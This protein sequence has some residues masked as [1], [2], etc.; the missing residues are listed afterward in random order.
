M[1]SRI[2]EGRLASDSCLSPVPYTKPPAVKR[3]VFTK[4][5]LR[6]HFALHTDPSQKEMRLENSTITLLLLLLSALLVRGAEIQRLQSGCGLSASACGPT[7]GTQICE[8]SRPTSSPE[9]FSSSSTSTS[10]VSH[11]YR[12]STAVPA[13]PPSITPSQMRKNEALAHAKA[14]GLAFAHTTYRGLVGVPLGVV[15]AGSSLIGSAVSVGK[16]DF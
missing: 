4:R 9:S 2:V 3:L 10:H 15:G 11:L 6:A 8:Y 7:C 1:A 14:A 12:R 5:I 16:G 13:P